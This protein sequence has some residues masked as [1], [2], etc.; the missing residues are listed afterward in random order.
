M[1][2]I[3]LMCVAS[4]LVVVT[5]R[6]ANVKKGSI[7]TDLAVVEMVDSA[8][9]REVRL[10]DFVGRDGKM[11]LIDFWFVGCGYCGMALPALGEIGTEYAEKLNVV[12]ILRRYMG[13]S[14]RK[15][16]GRRG[17][18]IPA[19]RRRWVCLCTQTCSIRR[20]LLIKPLNWKDGPVTCCSTG[21]AKCWPHGLEATK[22]KPFSKK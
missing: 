3:L 15:P 7:Y 5:A 21:T 12:S 13:R 10:S 22:S 1:R 6:S 11:T 9:F 4:M 8:T 2:K 18:G 16:I 17:P 19:R 20:V 14:S